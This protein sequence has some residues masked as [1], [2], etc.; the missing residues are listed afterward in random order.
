[1][2]HSS[3]LSRELAAKYALEPRHRT[4]ILDAL[5]GQRD[6]ADL[7][8]RSCKVMREKWHECSQRP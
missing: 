6:D 5:D 3:V 4:R 2:P 1:M 8:K 7:M